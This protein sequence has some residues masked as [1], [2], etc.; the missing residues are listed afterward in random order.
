MPLRQKIFLQLGIIFNDPVMNDHQGFGAVGMRMGVFLGRLAVGRPAGM[1]EPHG[2]LDRRFLEQGLQIGELAG[3][4]PADD[5]ALAVLDER[6]A[7]RIVAAVLK[8]LE[9]L[10]QKGRR[11]L[12][13]DVADYAAHF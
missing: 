7:R 3:S 13:A 10:H 6:Q 12:R 5:L 11:L 4:A 2:T 9:P 8:P 1:P